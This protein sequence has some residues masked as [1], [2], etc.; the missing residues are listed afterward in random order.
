M[1]YFSAQIAIEGAGRGD[2]GR[3]AHR[4]GLLGLGRGQL[5]RP[6]RPERTQGEHKAGS[7]GNLCRASDSLLGDIGGPDL[8]YHYADHKSNDEG[9]NL[10]V[11][12]P[13]C[14]SEAEK[15]CADTGGS[16]NQSRR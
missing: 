13:N 14:F 11:G 9:G 6:A 2:M 4:A 5:V 15:P 10:R 16:R 8:F 12:W 1:A 3:G 7:S